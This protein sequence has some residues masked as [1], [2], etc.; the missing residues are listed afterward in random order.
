MCTKCGEVKGF[1]KFH[2]NKAAKDGLTPR[3]KSCNTLYQQNEERRASNRRACLKYQKSTKGKAR[4][5]RFESR[6]PNRIKAQH[7]VQSAIRNR[8]I[9]KAFLFKCKYCPKQ[10]QQY[11]HPRYEPENW[12]KIE[13]VCKE[14]HYKCDKDKM[15]VA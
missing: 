6:H 14:C 10:A 15:K 9:Q 11:H 5:K 3:C 1:E 13:P 8:T 2:K 4:R 7:A 12:L